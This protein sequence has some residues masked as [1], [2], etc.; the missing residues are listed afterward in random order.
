MLALICR[1]IRHSCFC[2]TRF[3]V[4]VQVVT[5]DAD[6]QLI[7]VGTFEHNLDDDVISTHTAGSD[8][9]NRVKY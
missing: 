4:I 1:S 8:V 2:G 6:A 9:Q 3:A 7:A 5:V